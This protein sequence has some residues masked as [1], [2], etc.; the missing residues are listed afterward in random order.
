M[1]LPFAWQFVL[2]IESFKVTKTIVWVNKSD[3]SH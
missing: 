1:N 2:L 3:I